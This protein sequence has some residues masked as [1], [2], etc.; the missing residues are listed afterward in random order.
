MYTV[1]TRGRLSKR[2]R[3]LEVG[4]QIVG[5]VAVRLGTEVPNANAL[6]QLDPPVQPVPDLRLPNVQVGRQL[7]PLF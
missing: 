4:I 5:A 7:A 3:L 6:G 1:A 2:S